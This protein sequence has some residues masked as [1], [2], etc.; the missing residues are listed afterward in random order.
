MAVWDE[1]EHSERD[2]SGKGSR[3]MA[4]MDGTA[5]IQREGSGKGMNR[6]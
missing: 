4:V 3:Q 1:T 5:H 6:K 2:R